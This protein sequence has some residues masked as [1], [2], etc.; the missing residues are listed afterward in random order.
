M[1]IDGA[2]RVTTPY[3]PGFIA[4][5]DTVTNTTYSEVTG[6]DSTDY[7]TGSC[8]STSTGRFTAPVAGIY[9]FYVTMGWTNNNYSC[10]ICKNG[11]RAMRV[12]SNGSQPYWIGTTIAVSLAVGDYVSL[13]KSSAGNNNLGGGA[14]GG[15]GGCL[16][17]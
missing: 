7:N 16:L 13:Y 10:D 8:F 11:S 6:Y 4:R 12:E 2:G 1:R 15:F 5:K 17:G 3:K 14:Q 9:L